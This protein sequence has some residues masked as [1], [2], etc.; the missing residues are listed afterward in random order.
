MSNF[1]KISYTLFEEARRNNGMIAMF[2]VGCF[3]NKGGNPHHE[4]PP[5]LKR[6]LENFPRL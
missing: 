5:V 2:L 1:N 6:L 3:P 4:Y